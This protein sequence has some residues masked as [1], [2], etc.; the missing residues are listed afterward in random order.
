MGKTKSEWIR[1]DLDDISV[2]LMSYRY[3]E[4]IEVKYL[5]LSCLVTM[6][7]STQSHSYTIVLL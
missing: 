2:D 4:D 7:T 6:S 5:V 3:I 1:T